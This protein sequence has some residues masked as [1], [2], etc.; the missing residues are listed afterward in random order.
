MI[1]ATAIDEKL[2]Q[3]RKYLMERY[4]CDKADIIIDPLVWYITTG[5]ASVAFLKAFLQSK[6]FMTARKLAK[7]RTYDDAVYKLKVL[8][9]LN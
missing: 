8:Y 4:G 2:W 1:N 9:G 5:R 3:V 7:A 6:T